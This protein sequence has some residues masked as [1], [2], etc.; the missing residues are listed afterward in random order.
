MKEE[1]RKEEGRKKEEEERRR[2]EEEKE[3]E[4]ER[5][6]RERSTGLAISLGPTWASPCSPY[7]ENRKPEVT[8]TGWLRPILSK[9]KT[10]S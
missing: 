1:R 8:A 3:E 6:G 9:N 5:G 10:Q 4:E 2:E 7:A